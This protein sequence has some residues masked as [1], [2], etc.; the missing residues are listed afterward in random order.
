M[1]R[2]TILIPARNEERYIGACLDAI[3]E[4]AKPFEG[5]VE[6][7]VVLNRCTD[8][9]EEIAE[10]HGARIVREDAKNL[11]KI[12][13]AAA[14]AA[15]G[16]IL[17]TIDADSLMSPN[18]LIEIDHALSSGKYIGGGVPIYPERWS[19]GILATILLGMPAIAALRIS[20]GLFWCYRDDFLAIGGFDE[21]IVIA[22]D[23]NF[24]RRLKAY[25][26]SKGKRFKM[27]RGTRITT[28]CRK[29][30]RWGDWFPVRFMLLHPIT[31]WR[32]LLSGKDQH[33][34]NH[35]FYDFER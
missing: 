15:S 13:N 2:F 26:K 31:T 14:R 25:G 28:S 5:Q 19:P 7:V 34:A 32:A 16:D 1:P 8:R 18:M 33:T 11:S 4:A 21:D 12:R 29:F 30:D 10:A 27:L 35:F 6:L 24:A 9:T 23:V 3:E 17:V 20:A 22:E